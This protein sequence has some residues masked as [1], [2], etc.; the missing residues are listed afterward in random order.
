MEKVKKNVTIPKF[1]VGKLLKPTKNMTSWST[2]MQNN[3]QVKPQKR[4][5]A[6]LIPLSITRQG[7]FFSYKFL[8]GGNVIEH[9]MIHEEVVCDENEVEKAKEFFD[10]NFKIIGEKQ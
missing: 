5:R 7:P 6:V 10:E 4:N 8:F 2:L 1:Y 3:Q 9:Y